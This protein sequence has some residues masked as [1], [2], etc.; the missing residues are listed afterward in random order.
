MLTI[1][2]E[3]LDKSIYN[4]EDNFSRD[5]SITAIVMRRITFG[6]QLSNLFGLSYRINE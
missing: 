1:D 2:L 3:F 6:Y 5:F 4:V